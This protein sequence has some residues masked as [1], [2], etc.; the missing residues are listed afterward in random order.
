M[1]KYYPMIV[2]LNQRI[3]D[4]KYHKKAKS[5]LLAFEEQGEIGILIND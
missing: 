4:L 2:F 3:R 5:I 1:L